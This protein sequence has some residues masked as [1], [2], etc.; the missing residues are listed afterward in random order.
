VTRPPTVLVTDAE[1]KNALAA[2]RSL[3]THGARVIVGSTRKRLARGFYSRYAAA[4][5][6]YP[7]PESEADFVDAV[8][9][10]VDSHGVDVVLPIGDATNRV[11]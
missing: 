3:G 4:R 1:N 2:V 7:S 8:L 9:E 5:V 6:T 10:I 11:T